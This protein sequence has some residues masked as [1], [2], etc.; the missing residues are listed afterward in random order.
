MDVILNGQSQSVPDHSTVRE[1][2]HA[3]NTHHAYVAVAIND[4]VIPHSQHD[5]TRLQPH[6]RIEIVQAVGGG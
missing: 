2:L 1:V 5:T 6:D 4:R 3:Q